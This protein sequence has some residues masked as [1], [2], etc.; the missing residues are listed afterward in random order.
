MG[1]GPYFVMGAC[2]QQKRTPDYTGKVSR[3]LYGK[4]F[5]SMI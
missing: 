1:T 3:K 4:D 5:I 2:M